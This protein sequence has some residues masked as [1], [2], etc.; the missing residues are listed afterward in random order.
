MQVNRARAFNHIL[1]ILLNIQIII[2]IKDATYEKC[3][4][5]DLYI[6]SK[7]FLTNLTL[8]IIAKIEWRETEE[9]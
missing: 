7:Y 1:Y 5:Q 8:N 4:P 6:F 9:E 2:Y 3:V